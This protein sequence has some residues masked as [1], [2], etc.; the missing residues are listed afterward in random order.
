MRPFRGAFFLIVVSIAPLLHKWSDKFRCN[1]ANAVFHFGASGDPILVHFRFNFICAD[2][3]GLG[4]RGGIFEVALANEKARGIE[5]AVERGGAAVD[6]DRGSMLVDEQLDGGVDLCLVERNLLAC[7]GVAGNQ[8]AVVGQFDAQRVGGV[9][10]GTQHNIR[11]WV[12]RC[13]GEAKQHIST[14]IQIK[15]RDF[16]GSGTLPADSLGIV[17]VEGVFERLI[18]I[19]GDVCAIKR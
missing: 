7:R 1:G 2:E 15:R 12:R 19:D 10:H 4:G 18:G 14:G 8:L 9:A 11:D 13:V 3:E 16:D 6:R 5:G 17:A